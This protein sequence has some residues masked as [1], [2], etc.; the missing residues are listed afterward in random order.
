MLRQ[1]ETYT[2]IIKGKC[3]ECG[4]PHDK[5]I[6]SN[7]TCRDDGVRY[8]RGEDQEGWCVFACRGCSS[9]ISE[10]FEADKSRGEKHEGQK[11]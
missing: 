7:M 9:W 5:I 11:R 1:G 6:G 4:A 3:A 10:T 8:A 2:E